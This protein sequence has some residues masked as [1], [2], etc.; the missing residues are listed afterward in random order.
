MSNNLTETSIF[1][2]GIRLIQTNDI[3]LGGIDGVINIQATQL[4]NRTRWLKESIEILIQSYNRPSGIVVLGDDGKILVEQLP[5]DLLRAEARIVPGTYNKI[6]LNEYGVVVDA[7][8]VTTA[9]ELGLDPALDDSTI[10]DMIDQRFLEIFESNF[11]SENPIK[12]DDS[13][14]KI[15]NSF[16]VNTL[17]VFVN[18]VLQDLGDYQL[19]SRLDD[20]TDII[21]DIPRMETDKISI[22]YFR[23]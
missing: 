2:T 5:D 21:F 15:L 10:T 6:T 9:E 20:T 14:F 16:I 11:V 3:V 18:G 12:I 23:K 7:C 13:T 4:A 17:Q 19:E 1:E 22:T 8:N